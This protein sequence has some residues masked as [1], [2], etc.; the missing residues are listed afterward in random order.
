M[1]RAQTP[2]FRHPTPSQRAMADA[3]HSHLICIFTCILIFT[4]LLILTLPTNRPPPL[5]PINTPC[6][7]ILPRGLLITPHFNIPVLKNRR[8]TTRPHNRKAARRV[9]AQV[10]R[11]PRVHGRDDQRR[12]DLGRFELVDDAVA[13]R[14]VA[15]G[16]GIGAGIGT[17]TVPTLFCGGVVV[18]MSMGM[19]A[20]LE[21]ARDGVLGCAVVLVCFQVG[22]YAYSWEE[23]VGR[24]VFEAVEG[25]QDGHEVWGPGDDAVHEVCEVGVQRGV[26]RVCR[27]LQVTARSLR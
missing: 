13:V 4:P 24:G 22:V 14:R 23:V 10:E 16:V 18:S 15:G 20:E 7:E 27:A 25:C 5:P 2:L 11:Q 12:L 9:A 8:F 21:G 26:R 19:Q 17:G 6:I 1:Q 3:A